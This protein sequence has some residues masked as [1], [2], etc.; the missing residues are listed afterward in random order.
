MDL[1]EV[2]DHYV[3]STD[4]PGLSENEIDITFQDGVL[5]IS[6]E[7]KAMH[8]QDSKGYLRLERPF[9]AFSRSLSLPD[10]VDAGSLAAR[11]D[12]G[13][14]MISI[15]KPQRSQPR[16]VTIGGHEAEELPAIEATETLDEH[17]NG[18]EPASAPT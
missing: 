17:A 1:V 10:G 2:D 11:F 9:G 14:L 8:G 7:R 16:K 15:P 13:V 18:R 12:H 6:G 4:L 3:L 5:T